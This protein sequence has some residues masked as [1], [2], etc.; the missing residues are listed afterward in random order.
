M[1]VARAGH[2]APEGREAAP[3]DIALISYTS[4]TSGTP[5]GATNTHGN[6][7]YNAER[8]RTGLRAARGARL[9]RARAAV[10]HHRHGLPARRRV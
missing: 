4:G 6:I 10:P 3:A 1:A 2:K 8:Q 9:L 7:M 5:K